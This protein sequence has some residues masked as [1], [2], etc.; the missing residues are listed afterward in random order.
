MP[1][2]VQRL[3]V[4]KTYKLFIG[5]KFPRTESGRYLRAHD[6][7]TGEQLANYCHASRKDL[8]NAVTAAR[9][10]FPGWAAKSAYL[11]GQIIYRIAEMIESRSHA[12]ADEITSSSATSTP[13]ALAEVAATVDRLVHFAG[14]SDKY[15]QVFSSVNP[16][17]SPHFNFS[18]L[19][20]TGVV[21]IVCPDEPCL[22]ALASLTAEAVLSGNCTVA[23]ASEKYPLPAV[24]FAEALATSDVPAGVINI[25]TGKRDELTPTFASH[26]DIN[27]IVDASGDPALATTLQGGVA[28]NL[29]RVSIRDLTP[30]GWTTAAARDP[31]RILDTVEVKT[32]WHPAG[33]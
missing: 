6:V 7:K 3:K 23:L 16:V 8:R 5:G 14:W 15:Q 30:A 29:K 12:I 22:L 18:T 11:R 20:P 24:A 32:A 10:A 28:D 2:T 19:E 1:E 31:Y 27:A 4:L 17:A 9:S 21:G 13:D 33:L 26:M 25:L